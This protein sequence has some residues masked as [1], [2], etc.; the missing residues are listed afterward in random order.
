M[1]NSNSNSPVRTRTGVINFDE[2]PVVRT[3]FIVNKTHV[4][5]LFS[6]PKTQSPKSDKEDDL[7][8]EIF[9]REAKLKTSHSAN[10]T[11]KFHKTERL[12]HSTDIKESKK[13][14]KKCEKLHRQNSQLA[15]MDKGVTDNVLVSF[16]IAK[17]MCDKMEAIYNSDMSDFDPRVFQSMITCKDELVFLVITDTQTF[18]FYQ[19]DLVPIASKTTQLTV[20]SE[21]S[22]LFCQRNNMPSPFVFPRRG[23]KKPCLCLYPETSNS[24]FG[25]VNAFW[26]DKNGCIS[27][28]PDIRNNFLMPCATLN[29]LLMNMND[30][31]VCNKVIVLRCL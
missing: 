27:F 29:P 25:C 19:R 28:Y 23:A 22:F 30:K 20:N 9:K 26:I 11:K 7:D 12:C 4:S 15:C 1:G 10:F 24:V 14:E 18:G 17:T 6:T 21:S 8:L 3:T 31:C 2:S 16:L 5:P 13:K